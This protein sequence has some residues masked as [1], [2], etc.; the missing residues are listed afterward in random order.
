MHSVVCCRPLDACCGVAVD[1]SRRARFVH[2]NVFAFDTATAISLAA[3]FLEPQI[4]SKN[5]LDQLVVH[6]LSWVYARQIEFVRTTLDYHSI[7]SGY[8][9]KETHKAS[10]VFLL[11]KLN[12]PLFKLSKALLDLPI[13]MSRADDGARRVSFQRACN[14]P[15]CFM[16]EI[17]IGDAGKKDRII[18]PND[19]VRAD[20]S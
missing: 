4:K 5:L 2:T 12:S 8:F 6:A 1:T 7:L 15:V 19:S 17:K 3:I 16:M 18:S 11:Q 13:E 20:T 14:M 10:Q 9:G